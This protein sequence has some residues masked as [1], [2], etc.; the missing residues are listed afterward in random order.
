MLLGAR[1]GG[2]ASVVLEWGALWEGAVSLIP[3]EPLEGAHVPLTGLPSLGLT[4]TQLSS[5]LSPS[6]DTVHLGASRPT[7]SP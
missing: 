2:G 7:V 5:G 3:A 1:G 4:A 6:A